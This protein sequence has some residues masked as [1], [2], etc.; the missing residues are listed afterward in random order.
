MRR[1]LGGRMGSVSR[2][3]IVGSEWRRP[4]ASP[5]AGLRGPVIRA[6]NRHEGQ[7]ASQGRRMQGTLTREES[8]GDATRSTTSGRS[9]WVR[10]V[11]PSRDLFRP[12]WRFLSCFAPVVPDRLLFRM[13]RLIRGL[14]AG[15]LPT[16]PGGFPF[17]GT[18]ITGAGHDSIA[19]GLP[20]LIG[21]MGFNLGNASLI[22][23]VK[24]VRSGQEHLVAHIPKLVCVFRDRGEAR[25]QLPTWRGPIRFRHR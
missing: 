21:K 22:R 9:P 17:D 15:P 5:A 7:E 3:A 25:W 18:R 16:I 19:N 11:D 6:R 23:C 20:L 13:P 8:L 14:R 2:F 1:S 12:R 10:V 24:R 4:E